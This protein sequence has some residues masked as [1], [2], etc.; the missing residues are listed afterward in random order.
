VPQTVQVTIEGRPGDRAAWRYEVRGVS[1]HVVPVFLLDTRLPEN[2]AY[3]QAL[4]DTLYGGDTRYRL[5][6][7][8]VLGMGGAALLEAMGYGEGTQYHI[9]EG[10]AALLC[11]HHLERQLAGRSRGR[12]RSATS[13]PW[14]R[15]ASSRRT[16]RAAGHDRFAMEL[17]RAVLGEKAGLARR[18]RAVGGRELNMTRLRCAARA[19]STASRCG[20]SRCRRRCSPSSR[21]A[22]SRTACTRRRGRPSRSAGCSTATPEWRR[23]NNYLRYA[24]TIPIEEIRAA[25]GESK[26]AMLDEVERRTG[27]R[28]D[29]RCSRS[30]S[31]GAPR[32]TSAPT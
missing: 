23:D 9:N 29:R 5:C 13:R 8:V 31:R 18:R 1:D 6:Q 2:S 30:A 14:P 28:L 32:R 15:A 17:V 3:D 16:R 20:T 12:C 4:T 27:Q 24:I 22:P 19:S 11:L 7:E 10:H 21:S 26:Q 25:H